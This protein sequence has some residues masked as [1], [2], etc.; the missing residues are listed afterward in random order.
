MIQTKKSPDRR[1]AGAKYLHTLEEDDVFHSIKKLPPRQRILL[2]I[3]L[4]NPAGVLSNR[5][6]EM[7]KFT[8]A[9]GTIG[10]PRLDPDSREL[11]GKM[12]E[13]RI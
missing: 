8:D 2:K 6:R 7:E 1:P 5:L 13:K 12:L 11:A 10:R 9:D 4:E 3:L